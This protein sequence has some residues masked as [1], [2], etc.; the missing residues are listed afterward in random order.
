MGGEDFVVSLSKL[1]KLL[2]FFKACD[3]TVASWNDCAKEHDWV[4]CGA[5]AE[6]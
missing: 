5:F 1:A 4:A 2:V 6:A 3:G